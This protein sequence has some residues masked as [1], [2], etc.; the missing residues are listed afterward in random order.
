MFHNGKKVREISGC[1]PSDIPNE[2]LNSNE[3]IILK[4]LVT[5]WPFVAAGIKSDQD[6]DA[7]L[8]HFYNGKPV[9]E[10]SGSAE[11]NGRFF[12]NDDVTA[13][14][15]NTET[16][17]MGAVLDKIA[18]YKNNKTPPAFYIGSTSVESVLP[19]FRS[20]NDLV[21]PDQNPM[22]SIWIGNKTQ[23]AC[24]YDA[25]D[26]IACVAVGKRRFTLFAP[27]QISNLYPGPI[28]F[29]PSGAAI[30][31]VD[32]NNPDFE[33]YPRF[34]TAIENAW[35]AELDAGDALYLPSM[36]WHQVEAL[37]SFNVLVNYWWKTTPTY[38]GPAINVLKHAM[39]GIRG[40]SENEKAGLKHVFDYYIF[41]DNTAVTQHIPDK[42]QGVLAPLDD[43]SA[44]QLRT[45][46]V[47]KL[48]R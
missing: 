3:P 19:G 30:S 35:V 17:L 31:M 23:I 10:Y 27:D 2:I 22:V 41:G 42:A 29:T 46:L 24:H 14:N 26:N 34:Q 25:P 32:F 18:E 15:F 40:L 5:A 36:W 1:L 4:G 48:N 28:D 13:L 8:R 7:Y 45:W 20:E 47:N 21:I 6:A 43:I 44:R 11:I 16:V 33:K 9:L 37:N 12:Y 39:L 38:M